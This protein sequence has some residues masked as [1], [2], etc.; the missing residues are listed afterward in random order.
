MRFMQLV[1]LFT[2]IV[3]RASLANPM[4]VL[5]HDS[6]D[7]TE[8]GVIACGA[9]TCDFDVGVD[10]TVRQIRDWGM[11]GIA[12][13]TTDAGSTSGSVCEFKLPRI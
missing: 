3:T 7:P 12:D 8:V 11:Q 13:S 4:C 10:A 2:S 9:F 6:P 1:M 5:G